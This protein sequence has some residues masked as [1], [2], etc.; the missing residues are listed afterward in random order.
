MSGSEGEAVLPG[1]YLGLVLQ[2][3]SVPAETEIKS[4]VRKNKHNWV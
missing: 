2:A 3:G 1:L 4:S